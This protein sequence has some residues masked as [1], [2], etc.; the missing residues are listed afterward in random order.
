[1]SFVM[2]GKIFF[3]LFAD[4]KGNSENPHVGEDED[5]Y[6]FLHDAAK[7]VGGELVIVKDGR[8]IWQVFNDSGMLGNSRLA[9]CSKELK[10][11]P[12]RKWLEDNCDPEDTTV[13][14]GIDWSE[15]HRAGAIRKA[16]EPY[17]VEMP[18]M[19]RP[20]LYKEEM[21]QNAKLQG[22]KPPRA[23]EQGYQHANCGGGCVRSGKGQFIKLLEVNRDRYMVWEE[24]EQEFRDKYQKDVTI[25]T[26]VSDGNKTPL[27]LLDLRLRCD[28]NSITTD[29]V[30]D[31]GGCGCFVDY[32]TEE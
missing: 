6:R 32:G 15:S 4:V 7:N 22:L 23:Y 26:E 11:A 12:S 14:V 1:M 3:L 13:W 21:I 10:Q 5:T 24:K 29:D 27:T 16:Y 17:R 30:L 28:S 9:L 2:E 25:L 8:D 20:F 31:V 18:M 19:D